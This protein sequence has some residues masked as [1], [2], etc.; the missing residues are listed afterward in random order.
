MGK[1]QE[2]SHIFRELSIMLEL[3]GIAWKPKAYSDA[4]REIESLP[5]DLGEIYKTEGKKGLK[6]IN[7][8]GEHI[9]L[10]IIEYL[11]TGKIENYEELKK[12]YPEGMIELTRLEGLGPKKVKRLRDELDIFSLSDL[13]KA[14]RAHKVRELE[15]FGEKTENNI[16][17]AF[18]FY[19]QR[20]PRMLLS[21]ALP[22]AEG[23]V[24]YM[25][26]NAPV[27]KI[28]YV[29][30]LRRMKE[31]IGDVDILAASSDPKKTIQAFT[32]MPD[33]KRVLAKGAAKSIVVLDNDIQIDLLVVPKKTYAAALQYFTGS[34]DHNIETR[35]IALKKGYK[36]SEHGL[37]LRKGDKLIDCAD[38]KIL[39][40][41]LGLDHVPPEMR[42]NRGEIE[43]AKKKS[44]PRLVETEDI[45]GD[46]HI[47]S[48]FSDGLESIEDIVK[49]AK[50]K[51]YEYIAITDH[52][53]SLAIAGGL[54]KAELKEQ[55][56]E[57]DRIAKK[58]KIKILKGAEV[59]ILPSGKL[60]YPE[61]VL[62]EL[63]MVLGSIHSKLK[64]SREEM[65][66]R[67]I[68]ALENPYLHIF[69]HPS[70]RVLN[71]RAGYDF[72]FEAVCRVAAKNKKIFEINCS[73]NRL[74]L[75]DERVM[76][77]K[78]YGIKFAI[79]SDAHSLF[80]LNSIRYGV[81]QARRG[82]LTKEDVVNAKS[83]KELKKFLNL[84]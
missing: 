36:L 27:E 53:V 49:H 54:S 12:K 29:G 77:A 64:A 4:A 40:K 37:F 55:W 73:P 10:H 63:D 46:L 67:I 72:D 1:N 70:G 84:H 68:R 20:L 80:G 24:A 31:T 60:D 21:N 65:T 52:S 5:R 79:N 22:I 48:N 6:K 58:N 41:K 76:T 42:E 43:L 71:M 32:S 34:K 35:K 51:G 11:A 61:D 56:R 9:A 38:E 69:C 39:Y 16:A 3:E 30:S 17:E 18:A 15:G 62:K 45:R 66:K 83:W 14:V 13:E 7:A 8:V 50:E 26:K 47:H 78:G 44:L 25:E 19:K 57:I 81:G 74:D 33:V 82:W 75:N 23:I 59:D 28:D 2:I